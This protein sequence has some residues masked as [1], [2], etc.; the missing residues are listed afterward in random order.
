MS[1]EMDCPDVSCSG[2][3]MVDSEGVSFSTEDVSSFLS[4]PNI[5]ANKIE[6][7]ITERT[8]AIVLPHIFG[9]MADIVEIKNICSKYN[10]K[11]IE[12]C[13]QSP[14]ATL[15]NKYA[16]TF[17][18]IGVFS[19][20]AHKVIQTGEG[21]VCVTDDDEL[22]LRLKLLRNH[23]SHNTEALTELKDAIREL[24]EFLLKNNKGREK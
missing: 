14:G 10:I 24:K 16:G 4:Q 20:N 18:D 8:K 13:A 15:N 9:L 23:I 11:I 5:D 6:E 1:G 3:V 2:A 7:N 17:G 22:A 21:G 12:D 19:L